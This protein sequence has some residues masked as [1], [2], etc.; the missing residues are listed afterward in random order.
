M[1]RVKAREPLLLEWSETQ[2]RL[3]FGIAVDLLHQQLR[4]GEIL[5]QCAPPAVITSRIAGARSTLHANTPSGAPTTRIRRSRSCPSGPPLLAC[6]VTA[7]ATELRLLPLLL[8]VLAAVFSVGTPVFDLALAA[9]VSAL[10][11]LR[12][13][14]FPPFCGESTR[15]AA[16][17]ARSK[18]NRL[19][20]S[21]PASPFTPS[22][23]GQTSRS[24][25][26]P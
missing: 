5:G 7:F 3:Y 23:S 22:V 9:G 8:T 10:V 16:E 12:H 1:A 18:P 25:R 6:G 21:I 15:A 2:P 11:R 13:D 14:G 4:E 26:E 24:D 17:E 19:V 20:G